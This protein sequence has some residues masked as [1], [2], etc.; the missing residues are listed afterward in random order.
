MVF[1]HTWFS[2]VSSGPLNGLSCRSL[3][4]LFTNITYRNLSREICQFV[5]SLQLGTL[6][7]T[8]GI[9]HLWDR[10]HP[11]L[12]AVLC[13][14]EDRGLR[15]GQW[16]RP[17]L[18]FQV[19]QPVLAFQQHQEPGA[20]LDWQP[21]VQSGLR[22]ERVDSTSSLKTGEADAGAHSCWYYTE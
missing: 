4:T 9:S 18:A 20:S 7:D 19:D 15:G 21:A 16:T 11:D 1:K 17:L 6:T 12:Q 3:V 14:L 22:W 13:S 10:D 8:G 5:S 2:L